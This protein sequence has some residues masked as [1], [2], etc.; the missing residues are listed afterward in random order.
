MAISFLAEA[1]ERLDH[2]LQARMSGYSRARIQ[3]WIKDGLVTSPFVRKIG[4][5]DQ[6]FR[7][8]TVPGL[9]LKANEHCNCMP[10]G[11]I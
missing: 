1:G 11:D 5:V 9:D 2:F 7:H 3:A 10:H 8:N 4:V 6:F